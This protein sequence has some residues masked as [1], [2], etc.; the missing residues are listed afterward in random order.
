MPFRYRK[1]GMRETA[2]ATAGG[3]LAARGVLSEA[4]ESRSYGRPSEGSQSDSATMDFIIG[5][6]GVCLGA[7]ITLGVFAGWLIKRK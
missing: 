2:S 3:R 1:N 4:A 6:P 7:A 5:H